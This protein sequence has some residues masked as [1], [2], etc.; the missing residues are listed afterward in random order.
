MGMDWP[1][2]NLMHK[3]LTVL[4]PLLTGMNGIIETKTPATSV[5]R[6]RANFVPIEDH[7]FRQPM[8]ERFIS[9][10]ELLIWLTSETGNI[11]ACKRV[12]S[13]CKRLTCRLSS[14]ISR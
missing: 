8:P 12:S 9:N 6:I 13:L 14:E 10:I 1:I 5:R 3:E 11:P 4:I 2:R 7:Q